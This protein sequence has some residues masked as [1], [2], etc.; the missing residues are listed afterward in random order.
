MRFFLAINYRLTR[1]HREWAHSYR[2]ILKFIQL[3]YF[4]EHEATY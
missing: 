1:L 3:F 2:K 4:D